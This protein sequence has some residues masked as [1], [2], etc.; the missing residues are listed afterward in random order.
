MDYSKKTRDDL[1]TLCKEQK[2]KGY[3][4]K[5]REDLIALLQPVNIVVDDKKDKGQFYTTQSS[6]ILEGF[7]V[8][9]DA[10]CIIEPFAGQGDLID[11]VKQCSTLPIEAYDI[12]PKRDDI[13]QRDTLQDPP[14]YENAW[15]LTNPPYLARNKSQNKQFMINTIQMIYTNVSYPV[16]SNKEIAEEELLSFLL[17]SSS[18]LAISTFV[19]DTIS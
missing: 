18:P 11:W 2:I 16:L 4:N 5:K 9:T 6:Y 7:D 10:R 15:I 1:I 12:Q 19:V 14:N 8:P 17:D 3:S 13:Q